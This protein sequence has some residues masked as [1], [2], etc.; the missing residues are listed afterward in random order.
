LQKIAAP[1]ARGGGVFQ[2]Y[3]AEIYHAVAVAD[4]VVS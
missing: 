3:V 2:M 4:G 1:E